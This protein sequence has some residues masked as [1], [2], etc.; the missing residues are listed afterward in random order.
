MHA[1]FP[2]F[3]LAAACAAATIPETRDV[4]VIELSRRNPVTVDGVANIN[5]IAAQMLREHSKLDRGMAAFEVNTGQ[6]HPLSA[7]T[8]ESKRAVAAVGIPL[9]NTDNVMWHGTVSVGNP[10]TKYLVDFDTG[11][12]DFFIPAS[13]CKVN[14]NGHTRYNA[15]KSKSGKKTTKNFTLNYLDG[16][17][18]KGVVYDETVSFSQTVSG[19]TT[20]LKATG[21]AVGA[22]ST[23]SNSFQLSAFPADGLLG[24]A[25]PQISKFGRNGVIHSLISQG[26]IKPV[27]GLKLANSKSE[28]MLGGVNANKYKGSFTWAK[29][30]PV[31]FW[32][33]KVNSLTLKGKSQKANFDAVVDSGTT[34]IFGDEKTVRAIFKAVPGAKD[35]SKTIGPGIFTVPCNAVPT[36]TFNIGGMP[37]SIA[38]SMLNLGAVSAGSKDCI[39][40]LTITTKPFWVLGDVFLRNVYT[41]F[42]I[43]NKRV[44]F[45][46]LA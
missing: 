23:Y 19:K 39:A 20:T 13:D 26:Q 6:V 9:T 42:D 34:V 45:A 3:S 32:Q 18:V 22:A 35:A 29:V 41:Q 31:G 1:L 17:Q 44:G 25:F 11:S 14:C 30:N 38:P 27:F 24:L 21:A 40:A 43:G 2:L 33:I 7:R 8:H 12:A 15:T 5:G 36:L 10:P 46:K 37:I 28:L 4:H 16:S